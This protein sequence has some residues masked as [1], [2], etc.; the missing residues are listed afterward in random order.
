MNFF[1]MIRALLELL[2]FVSR[3]VHDNEQ[4]R[5]G[6]AQ[7]QTE[8]MKQDEKRIQDAANAGAAVD[9]LR[10]KQIDPFDLDQK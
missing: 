6:A 4:R 7:N 9:G 3:E 1:A 5:A 2:G 10:D 8:A